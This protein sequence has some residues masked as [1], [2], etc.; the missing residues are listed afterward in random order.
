MGAVAMGVGVWMATPALLPVAGALPAQTITTVAGDGTDAS[1]GDGGIAINAAIASPAGVAEDLA[2]SLYVVDSGGNKIRKVVAPTSLNLDT[3]STLAG[4]G[5]RGFGGDGG[6]ASSAQLDDP[7]GVAVDEHGNVFIADTGNNRV[8]E[9]V[10]GS[11][12]IETIAGDGG[13]VSSLRGQKHRD[14]LGNGG[15]ATGATLCSPTG[16]AV[17][18]AGNV[19]ISDTGHSEVRVV[20]AAGV[21]DDYAGD[22]MS[23]YHGDGHLSTKARLASPTSL[24]LNSE[25]DLYIADTGNSV[26]REVTPVQVISTFAGTGTPGYSGDGGAATNARL[27][28]PSGVGVDQLGEVFVADTENNRVRVV[29]SAGV[30]NSV[31]G[32]GTKGY[33]GDGG[34]ALDAEL[35]LPTGS[36]AADG[37]AVYFSDTA[38]NR[39]RGVFTGPPPVLPEAGWVVAL[40][41]SAI[42]LAVG[43][44]LIRRRRGVTPSPTH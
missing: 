41:A 36:I 23:G 33:S 13:C 20:N 44:L 1:S 19:Y 5:A 14:Q 37:T 15:P 28:A 16:V 32:T 42:L 7:R 22:G 30:I 12:V 8:R 9:V 43:Y 35:A 21:I 18:S 2:G 3:I 24:A 6:P 27:N 40:P 34:P 11:G 25:H 38:N 17:D 29:D 31:A 39:V 10:A 26:I 4:T